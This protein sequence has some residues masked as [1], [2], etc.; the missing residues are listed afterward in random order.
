[1]SM[2]TLLAAAALSIGLAAPAM[3]AP[4]PPLSIDFRSPAWTTD[5]SSSTKT[6][7]RVTAKAEAFTLTSLFPLTFGF[8]PAVL[9]QE[10]ED[11]LGVFRA[12]DFGTGDEVSFAERLT[13]S[14]AGA[15][16][17]NLTGVWLTDLFGPPDGGGDGEDGKVSLTLLGGGGNPVYAFNGTASDLDGQLY[18]AFG[19]ALD[20]TTAI[21]E[22]NGGLFDDYSV[23]G[24]TAQVPEPATLALF[25]AGLLGVGAF[26][27][28]KS[29]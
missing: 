6:V 25:G 8:V 26:R 1:M 29:A 23:A 13:I 24:F 28:R 9:S 2:K 5:G 7:G 27:R 3:A 4:I 20:I 14:F 11:G 10:A 18:L 17:Q 16:G 15:T 19:A 22:T 21:F 12:P